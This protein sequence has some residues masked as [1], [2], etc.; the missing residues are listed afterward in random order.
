MSQHKNKKV[1][2]LGSEGTQ[3]S[4]DKDRYYTQKAISLLN[5]YKITTNIFAADIIYVVWWNRLLTPWFKFYLQFFS[6]KIIAVITNDLSHQDESIKQVLSYIDIFVYANNK[7]KEKLLEL[8]VLKE[9]MSFSPFYADETLFKP[10][11]M[12][13]KAI[14]DYLNIPYEKIKE[15]F[16]IG[17]FQRDS[18][19]NDLSKPK[20]QKNP[21][22]LLDIMKKL[23]KE[24]FLL[25]LAGP[26]RHY[27][28]N[29]CKTYGINYIYIGDEETVKNNI[30]DISIN[31]LSIDKMPYLYNL[32][33]LYVV[34]SR[35][36]GGPKAIPESILCGTE[37]IST[38][39]GFAI[40]FLEQNK[41]YS[42][43]LDAT[44]KINEILENTGYK[45]IKNKKI[46]KYYDFYAFTKRIASLLDKVKV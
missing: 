10:L 17:S 8:G 11:K 33:D 1:F 21:D 4:I 43:S 34:S 22:M 3:W 29:S 20:W 39:V 2:L 16:L 27:L 12:D 37:I 6:P 40:C 7:Q 32:I 19:G 5:D 41:I 28:I 26:R 44:L 9:Q 25:V 24:K 30:D 38:D 18:L 45:K 14:C 13:K 46:K 15:K 36:E 42:D 35:S 31:S 23:D